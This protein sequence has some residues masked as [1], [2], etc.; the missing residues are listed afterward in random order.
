MYTLSDN[1]IRNMRN[2]RKQYARLTINTL[3]GGTTIIREDDICSSGLSINRYSSTSDRLEIGCCSASELSLRIRNRNGKYDLVDFEGAEISVEVSF[4]EETWIPCGLFIAD[5]MPRK[6]MIMNI[7]AL[8]RMIYFDKKCETSDFSL[9]MTIQDIVITCCNKCGVPCNIN[10]DYKTN[11]NYLVTEINLDAGYSFRNILQFALAIIG[12][13]GYIDHLG[14]LN[15]GWYSPTDFSIDTA[16]RY[17]SDIDDN[18]ITITGVSCTVEISED[19][20]RTY[21][22]GN[23]YYTLDIS[24]NI[25]LKEGIQNVVNNIGR[26][27]NGFNYRPFNAVIKPNPLLYPLDMINYVDI[28]GNRYVVP[29]TNITY[30]LNGNTIV[31]GSGESEQRNGYYRGNAFTGEASQAIKAEAKK[32]ENLVSYSVT[33]NVLRALNAEI[34]KLDA[35]YAHIDLANIDVAEI[36]QLFGDSAEFKDI[37]TNIANIGKLITGSAIIN[38]ASVIHL[39]TDNFEG[40]NGIIK[41]AMIENLSADKIQSGKIDTNVVEI[42]A[43]DESGSMSLL[44]SVMQFKDKNNV[45]RIQIGQDSQGSYNVIIRNSD[46]AVILDDKGV[47]EDAI[48]DGLIINEMISDDT[49]IDGNKLNIGDI[50][51]TIN[52]DGSYTINSGAIIYDGESLTVSFDSITDNVD[53]I[54]RDLNTLISDVSG[55]R[56]T[57]TESYIRKDEA[58]NKYYD[59]DNVDAKMLTMTTQFSQTSNSFE[60]N[61]SRIQGQLDD[62]N[63][64]IKEDV[65]TLNKYVRIENGDVIVGDVESPTKFIAKNNK[66]SFENVGNEIAYID[67]NEI[68]ITNAKI[69]NSLK[70]GKFVFVP[71]RNGSLDF[72]KIERG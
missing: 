57:V 64:G 39:K 59:K 35:K 41:S 53:D 60:F 25:L 37:V 65:N 44:G 34:S 36:K 14:G 45:V 18:S 49:K 66:I 13:N 12:E 58:E 2:W 24:D 42:S 23:S 70:L 33:A 32:I 61:F 63:G 15:S 62:L 31:S 9:P 51:K 26:R 43:T 22:S 20:S 72:K 8:D 46:G 6:R 50:V 3:S 67:A 55:L 10:W 16:D 29:I 69:N 56:S 71:K 48:V 5:K 1:D 47:T 30:A 28:K 17:S 54:N 27:I 4:D 68:S 52:E 40:D 19:E 7:L 11:I 38:D 21:L